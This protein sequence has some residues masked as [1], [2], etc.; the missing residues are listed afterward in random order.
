MV[1]RYLWQSLVTIYEQ[2]T[3]NFLVFKFAH[4]SFDKFNFMF[5]F[6]P[7][8]YYFCLIELFIRIKNIP[9][10]SFGIILILHKNILH[11]YR[12]ISIRN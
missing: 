8:K 6:D 1:G 2:Q 10:Y 5:F 9:T 4:M 12:V 3:I 7:I 11:K